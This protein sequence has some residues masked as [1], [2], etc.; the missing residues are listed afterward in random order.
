MKKMFLML[1]LLV[2]ACT[3]KANDSQKLSQQL[4]HAAGDGDLEGVETAIKNG[5]NINFQSNDG[6]TALMIASFLGKKD[7]VELLISNGANINIRDNEDSTALIIV[8]KKI[9][10]WKQKGLTEKSDI[11]KK[12]KEIENIL[13]EAFV[14]QM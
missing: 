2:A 10:Y 11:I 13:L 12:Y 1:P 7:V 6:Y 3:T 5:A 8:I 14:F 9:K 4:F